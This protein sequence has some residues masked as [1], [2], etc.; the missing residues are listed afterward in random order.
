MGMS[1]DLTIQAPT[2]AMCNRARGFIMGLDLVHPRNW[3]NMHEHL[4]AGGYPTLWSITDKAKHQP[5]GHIT[6]WDVAECIYLLM[7]QG[8]SEY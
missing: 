6:K 5:T 2:E 4:E 3:L 8:R 1:N 7:E